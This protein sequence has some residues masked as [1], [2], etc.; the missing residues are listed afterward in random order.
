[1]SATSTETTSLK[2]WERWIYGGVGAMAPLAVVA[3][4]TDTVAVFSTLTVVVAVAWTAKCIILFGIGG[5]VAFLHKTEADTWKCFVIGISAPALITTGLSGTA[6]RI[7]A[8]APQASLGIFSSAEAAPSPETLAAGSRIKVVPIS[9][10]AEGVAEQIKRGLFGIDPPLSLVVV[11]A[12][13]SESAARAVAGEV[14]RYSDCPAVTRNFKVAAPIIYADQRSSR[15]VVAVQFADRNEAGAY[16]RMLDR[17]TPSRDAA[18]AVLFTTMARASQALVSR[19]GDYPPWDQAMIDGIASARE[20]C[21][22]K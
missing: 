21:L 7:N 10:L 1:M 19:I 11:S 17:A 8:P 6:A 16:A 22:K 3:A 4:T 2:S 14:A 15:F 18:P 12:E 20:T 5:F 9:V 13:A